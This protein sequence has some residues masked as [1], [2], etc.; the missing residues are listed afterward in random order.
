MPTWTA[1]YSIMKFWNDKVHCNFGQENP[2]ITNIYK[3]SKGAWDK[4]QRN[5]LDFANKGNPIVILFAPD[6]ICDKLPDFLSKWND[7][8]DF[9]RDLLSS[10]KIVNRWS[11]RMPRHK[12]QDTLRIFIILSTDWCCNSEHFQTKTETY[13]ATITKLRKRRLYR[14][15]RLSDIVN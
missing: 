9:E 7:F 2:K 3:I 1:K 13:I 15:Y 11:T 6:L 10:V 12:R 8:S 5:R 4:F 14:T